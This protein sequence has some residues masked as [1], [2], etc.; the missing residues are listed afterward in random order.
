MLSVSIKL[1]SMLF[2]K[3]AGTSRGVL[4]NKPSWFITIKDSKNPLKVGYGECSLIPWLSFDD[5]P[6]IKDALMLVK[7]EIELNQRFDILSNDFFTKWPSI[8]FGLETAVKDFNIGQDR[9]LYPGAF[10]RGESPIVINGLIWMGDKSSMFKQIRDKADHGWECIKMKIGA[11]DFE[12]EL[13]LLR[14]IRKHFPADQITLRVDANGAFNSK[15]ALEKLKQLSDLDIH[16]IEQPIASGQIQQMA[17]LCQL[18]PL[19]IALDEEL[20]GVF[21][22]ES[23]VKLLQRIQP[24]YIILKPSLLGGIEASKEWINIAREQNINY[25]V[26]S[27]L[28]S[29]I[30]LNAIAQWTSTLNPDLPQGLG[31][32]TLFTNNIESPLHITP[33]LLH[34]N[35]TKAW[36]LKKIS[37][38]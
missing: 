9:I 11:I 27:A 26:T 15:N 4:K 18:S 10:T 3:P 22:K 34:Y 5:D 33:G 16:S 13:E 14:Y 37:T 32:G 7:K 1:M 29:N 2:K 25:W 28:E 17:D 6:G 38:G 19:D 31:T 35:P 21:D 23:K 20:I 8:K 36:N 24:A 12:D 30:G